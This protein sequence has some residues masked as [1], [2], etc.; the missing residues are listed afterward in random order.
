MYKRRFDKWEVKKNYTQ[1]DVDIL[2][3]DIINDRVDIDNATIHGKPVN[4]ERVM[5]HLDDTKLSQLPDL[6]PSTRSAARKPRRRSSTSAGSVASYESV[7]SRQTELIL[8]PIL[9][10]CS[11]TRDG[12]TILQLLERYLD[13][14]LFSAPTGRVFGAAALSNQG[15]SSRVFLHPAQLNQNYARGMVLLRNGHKTA[16]FALL[17]QAAT[18]LDHLFSSHHPVLASCLLDAFLDANHDTQPEARKFVTGHAVRAA[19]ATLG[20]NHPLAALCDFVQ[21]TAQSKEEMEHL[22]WFCEK[23]CQMFSDKLTKQDKV[24]AYVNLKHFAKLMQMQKLPAAYEHL[25]NHVEPAFVGF[26]ESEDVPEQMRPAALCY[27]R[28]K[29][30]LLLSIGD[31]ENASASLALAVRLSLTWLEGTDLS[32]AGNPLLEETFRVID[33]IAEYVRQT[34]DSNRALQIHAFALE[35]CRAVRGKREGKTMRMV[36]VLAQYYEEAGHVD[37]VERLQLR[38]PDVFETED[39]L[40]TVMH[41]LPCSN[42]GNGQDTQNFCEDHRMHTKV[43]AADRSRLRVVK[44]HLRRLF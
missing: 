14:H 17:A 38:F 21:M 7:D 2:F 20:A 6:K 28:R 10:P 37:E 4:W 34:G 30:H 15:S 22:L 32:V 11:K 27:L 41:V 35:L 9:E 31:V 29:A 3:D 39:T 12:G 19:R 26:L 44:D 16:G 25:T 24:T 36:S 8:S 18:A 1:D 5:R 42:C 33:E 13:A 23:F 40:D 43:T